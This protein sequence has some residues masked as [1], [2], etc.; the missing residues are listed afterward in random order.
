LNLD[1]NILTL[2]C[3]TFFDILEEVI[4]KR[5]QQYRGL[6]QALKDYKDKSKEVAIPMN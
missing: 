2:F 1:S 5:R 6:L 3:K 4:K